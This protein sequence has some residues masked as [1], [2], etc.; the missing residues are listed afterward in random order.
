M[1]YHLD[2]FAGRAE[3]ERSRDFR[4]VRRG[5][6]VSQLPFETAWALAVV[7]ATPGFLP[8]HWRALFQWGSRTWEE[9]IPL[10]RTTFEVQDEAQENFKSVTFEDGLFLLRALAA[11]RGPFK[12]CAPLACVNSLRELR[13]RGFTREEI[14][15]RVGV[16][17]EVVTAVWLQDCFSVF[18]GR[19]LGVG[20]RR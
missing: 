5:F 7:L 11:V 3:R 8:A 10:I 18:D 16:G 2:C 1:N 19:Y 4:L 6:K 9:E 13:S 17:V 15:V 20:A 14:A 12:R